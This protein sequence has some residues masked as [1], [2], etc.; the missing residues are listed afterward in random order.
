MLVERAWQSAAGSSVSFDDTY[1]DLASLTELIRSADL[2][3][4]PYDSEDQVTSG[5]L[6]DAVAAG[7]PVVSTA[8]PHAVELLG[9]GAG[10]VVPQRDPAALAAAIRSVLT[11]P[12]LAATM[13]TEARRLAPE[14][15]WSA[16][17]RRYD[18]LGT[19]LVTARVGSVVVRLPSFAHVLSM[20]DG[21]GIFEHADHAEPRRSHGYCTD[22]VARLLIVIVREPEHG[23]ALRELGRTAF[24]FL[25]EAQGVTGRTRNRRTVDGR[26]HGRRGV[27]DCWGR[28]IWAFGTAARRAPEEWMRHSGL[29]HFNRG[30]AR[31]GRRIV[32][33]WPSPR[34]ALP[35][36]WQSTLATVQPVSCSP[37]P[38]PGSVHC[39]PTTA[40]CGRNR[41]ARTPMPCCPK[42]SSP[43]VTSS[44]DP[45]SSRTGS[46][47]CVGC[48]IAKPSTVIISR[49]HRSAAPGHTITPRRSTNNR[50]R[51][52]RSPMPAPAP[53]R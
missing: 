16:V 13:A 9:G 8:F 47:C 43:P 27:E 21:I 6:V 23:H 4:L 40:G 51:S 34:S 17:A 35:R 12:D 31:S 28:T 30:L 44:A 24:R 18:A 1:R 39:Q 3:V 32:V 25:A 36:C 7:R 5:V 29:S 48:L 11:D 49:R 38:S 41:A 46:A 22:D 42:H 14:L 19:R 15:S 10:I 2:V 53:L 37:M 45:R 50:S 33:R 26:W 52:R 20:S